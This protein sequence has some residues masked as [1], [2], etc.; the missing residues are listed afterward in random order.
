MKITLQLFGRFREFSAAPELDLDLPGIAT[1]A[2]FRAA[3][4]AWAQA[5]WP[6]Y[7]PALLKASAIATESALLRA[8]STL[9]SDGRLAVLPP[10]SGG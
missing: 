5:H 10:V 6:A 3:F 7:A 9:P 2:D 1:V 8:D 4:D